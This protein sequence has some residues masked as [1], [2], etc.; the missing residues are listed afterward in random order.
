M[1]SRL[2]K[3]VEPAYPPEAIQ[4]GVQGDV[5]LETVIAADGHVGSARPVSGNPLLRAA[6]QEAVLQYVYRTLGAEMGST[7]TVAFRLPAGAPRPPG[8]QDP[9]VI[10]RKQGEY[11]EAARRAHVNGEVE[12]EFVIGTDGIPRD[13]QVVKSVPLLDQAAVEALRQWRFKPASLNG[14]PVEKKTRVIMTFKLF[15]EPP[16]PPESDPAA[17]SPAPQNTAPLLIYKRDPEYPAIARQVGQQGTVVLV[18]TIGADGR[19]KGVK[20]LKSPPMLAKPAR[21]AVMQWIYKPAMQDGAP[22]ESETQVEL[23]F[24]QEQT[25]PAAPPEPLGGATPP[26]PST[27][28][29]SQAMLVYKR[30][31]DYP[32]EARQAGVHGTVELLA[33][34]AVDGRVKDVKVVSGPPALTKAA[35]DAVTQWVYKPT[36]V[37]GVP[38]ENETHISISFKPQAKAAPEP[39]P[40]AAASPSLAPAPERRRESRI[41]A[42]LLS[43][44]DPKYPPKAK[45]MGARGIVRLEAI[46]GAD[47]HVRDVKVIESAYPLL[48]D[49]AV[50]AVR[51]WVYKPTLVDGVPV[52]NRTNISISFY[53]AK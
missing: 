32:E 34:I 45:K 23:N 24:P 31:P 3:K 36:M 44:V 41:N 16:R 7:A 29:I 26:Q 9:V 2:V 10:Y 35:Q 8:M 15:T 50:E 30:D 47:G 17:K 14:V 13:I 4:A 20:V 5:I 11:T 51:Q 46:I 33:T 21:D 18:A 37:N 25:S 1:E 40:P 38:V 12:M 27:P 52:E 53:G 48:S 49:A 42:V 28:Q 43:K 39:A 22:V 6:A 19:V